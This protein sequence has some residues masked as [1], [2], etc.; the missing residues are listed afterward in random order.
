[1]KSMRLL[2]SG[3]F[4]ALASSAGAGAEDEEDEEKS[5]KPKR[6]PFGE[7]VELL[8]GALLEEPRS[9]LCVLGAL[10]EEEEESLPQQ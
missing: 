4:E 8:A 2:R 6:P 5:P 7:L 10:E 9:I 1:M 3:I